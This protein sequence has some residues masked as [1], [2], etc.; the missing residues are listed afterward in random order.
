M[1]RNFNTFT[2]LEADHYEIGPGEK[3]Q[4]LH[5][6]IGIRVLMWECGDCSLNIA[7]RRQFEST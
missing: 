2:K 3:E 7:E 5:K 6:V 4:K 1:Y